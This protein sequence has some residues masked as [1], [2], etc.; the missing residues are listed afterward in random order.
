MATEIP[1]QSINKVTDL[2]VKTFHASHSRSMI[3]SLEKLC[4]TN[5]DTQNS[6]AEL[7]QVRRTENVDL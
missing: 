2:S 3:L 5:T 4:G 1:K 7:F 6:E